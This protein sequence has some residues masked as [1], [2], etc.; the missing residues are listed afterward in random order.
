MDYFIVDF[1][2][3]FNRQK[4]TFQHF[5]DRKRYKLINFAPNVE[6]VDKAVKSLILTEK[7]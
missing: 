7:K 1:H 3:L 5:S 2:R 4:A 6:I